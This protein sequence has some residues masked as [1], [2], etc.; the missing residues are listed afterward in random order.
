MPSKL[1]LI[2]LPTVLQLNDQDIL[3]IIITSYIISY[4]IFAKLCESYVNTDSP[5][6]FFLS[7]EVTEYCAYA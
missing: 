5:L 4:F 3:I 6:D 7:F 2:F 1:N